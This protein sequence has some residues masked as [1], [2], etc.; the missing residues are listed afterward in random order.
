MR[1]KYCNDAS[2]VGLTGWVDELENANVTFNRLMKDRYNEMAVK[3]DLV[4]RQVRLKIDEAYRI[5]V[6]H[7]NAAIVVEGEEKYSK[8][9]TELNVVIKKYADMLAQIKG[10]AA[11]KKR[12][13]EKK[14]P[15][16]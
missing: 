14:K 11:A 16:S 13:K 9:V 7:I 5:I 10:K 12:K 4:L 3:T 8:F 1:G 6:E 15:E 2:T